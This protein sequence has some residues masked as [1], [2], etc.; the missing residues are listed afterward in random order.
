MCSQ[1]PAENL[2]WPGFIAS[3]LRQY[4][5]RT[6]TLATLIFLMG[7]LVVLDRVFPSDLSPQ[8]QA[9][10]V[11]DKYGEPLRV[12]ADA[13]GQWRYHTRLEQVSPY[14]LQALIQYEDRWFYHHPGVN[15]F[16]LVRALG[17]WLANGRVISGASTLTMQV[18]RL[19]YPGNRGLGGKIKQ[20]LRALQLELH[21][22]KQE[23]L[24]Y[25][26]NHA[27]FGGTLMGVQAASHAY[28]GYDA[29]Q[30]TQA[31]AALLAVLPQ[32]PSRYRPDRY[33]KRA[34]NQRDKVLDR[35][36][37][38]EVWSA[39]EVMEAKME[40]VLAQPLQ[41]QL[42][43]P[44]LS[45]RLNKSSHEPLIHTFIDKELQINLAYLA[46]DYS[47][48]LPDHAS[49]AILVMNHGSG[50]V[51]AYIGSADFENPNRYAH[52]DMVTASRSPG[53]T[54]KPFIYALA[55]DQGLIHSE[56]LLMDVPL[57]FGEYRPQNFS[58]GFSGPVSTSEALSK[59]LNLPAVQIMEQLGSGYFYSRLQS[60]GAGLQ[61]PV[62]AKAN[63]AIALGGTATSLENLVRLYSALANKGQTL[64]PRFTPED[65]LIKRPLLSKESA[66]ITRKMLNRSLR[67]LSTGQSM[68]IKTGTSYGNRDTWAIGVTDYH[69]IGVWVG[70][71]DGTP[72]VGHFGN[73]TAVPLLKAAA[74]YLSDQSGTQSHRKPEW[75]TQR[76]IC[77]PQGQ[78][79]NHD[80]PCDVEKTAWLIEETA[81]PTLMTTQAQQ[82]LSQS[83]EIQFWQ[84]KDTGKRV[85]LGCVEDVEKVTTWLWP[86]PV[87][88]WLEPQFQT[89]AK[90]PDLDHRCFKGDGLL[91]P[92]PIQI[93]GIE[94]GSIIRRHQ[95]S[96]DQHQ[97]TLRVIGGQ[98]DWYWFLNGE[99]QDQNGNQL[100]VDGSNKGS[101]HISVMDQAGMTDRIEFRV[102]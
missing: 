84:A 65:P 26:L 3:T 62:G 6:I 93:Q 57:V 100:T 96:N 74:S 64:K 86:A 94:N 76:Q 55:M 39:Q 68:A 31:Q 36:A 52:V 70:K 69:T 81:P 12:F 5:K 25:Y 73:Y 29:S 47:N 15:P 44:L 90:V 101:Y 9:V 14:Y 21:Y 98:P 88:S 27:P 34:Q 35:L 95:L 30:L 42:Q 63:L 33:P 82:G 16:A 48:T 99:L 38:F 46:K 53:S 49:L 77:W 60:A 11:L 8:Q 18:A 17:Q 89:P 51:I 58:A 41:A 23:I 40:N 28:F 7:L 43:A 32:A 54:L 87:Q 1:K 91:L 67:L 50:K 72:M 45:R 2:S 66:W 97:M 80:A 56:S 78:I 79:K 83:S 71:P 4:P 85:A 20:M 13:K 24:T 102:Q 75:V 37:S 61:L 92:Q 22:S 59:S 19:R 10:T